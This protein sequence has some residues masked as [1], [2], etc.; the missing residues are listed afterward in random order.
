LIFLQICRHWTAVALATPELWSSFGYMLT[1]LDE[2]SNYN[3]A[4]VNQWLARAKACPLTLTLTS[5]SSFNRPSH[6]VLE[7][8]VAHSRRWQHIDF[9][10][11][12][13]TFPTLDAIKGSLPLLQTL[14]I[15][16]RPGVPA[17]KLCAFE[18]AP[19]LRS[20]TLA[21]NI[22]FPHL[23]SVSWTQL[24]R[25]SMYVGPQCLEIFQHLANVSKL[26]LTLDQQSPLHTFKDPI[27]F[28][29]LRTLCIVCLGLPD[30]A[31][32]WD[33]LVVPI[34]FD[35]AFKRNAEYTSSWGPQV[36]HYVSRWPTVRRVTLCN[37][38]MTDDELVR[39][40]QS[41][42]LLEKLEIDE[43][44]RSDYISNAFMRLLQFDREASPCLAPKL[45]YIG[46]KGFYYQFDDE[47][48]V[49]MVE[50]RWLTKSDIG[51]APHQVSRLKAVMLRPERVLDRKAVARL[52]KMKGEGLGVFLFGH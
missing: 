32:F 38:H 49:D 43:E 14:E 26:K 8:F 42:P 37:A 35:I 1:P 4:M 10:L 21:T 40:V 27:N 2:R 47:V 34:L 5:S 46:F 41:I 24:K 6:P 15:A 31:P 17:H 44:E 23:I 22:T 52:N 9:T 16:C 19:S 48:F 3:A 25:C 13:S 18:D 45:Q 39:L 11:P 30:P 12:T 29:L 7:T 33:M 50:S 51:D 36:L 28:P 20:L